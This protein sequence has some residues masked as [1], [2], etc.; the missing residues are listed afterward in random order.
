MKAVYDEATALT[1]DDKDFVIATVVHTQGSTPQKPGAA[2]LAR[3]DGST[4]GTLSQAG[5]GVAGKHQYGSSPQG[6][7]ASVASIRVRA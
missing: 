4:V 7:G 3:S 5:A 1:N 6:R 2:L